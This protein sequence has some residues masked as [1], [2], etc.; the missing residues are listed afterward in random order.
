MKEIGYGKDYRYD[1][2]VE[3]GFS[4]ADYWPDDMTPQTFYTPT[5]RGFEK[6]IA[7]RLAWWSE[8][9]QTRPGD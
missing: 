9:R 3:G 6:R 1:H 7:E 4:G 2:D 8:Q 5:E